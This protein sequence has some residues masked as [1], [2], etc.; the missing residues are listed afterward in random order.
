MLSFIFAAFAVAAHNPTATKS[1]PTRI[2]RLKWPSPTQ[3]WGVPPTEFPEPDNDNK[4]P[5][6]TTPIII[7]IVVGCF[8]FVILVVLVVI[9]IIRKRKQRR[10]SPLMGEEDKVE[11]PNM[12]EQLIKD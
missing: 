12:E 11:Q 4:G 6:I 8:V 10:E 7:G 1:W 5:K 3:E 2:P 9:L